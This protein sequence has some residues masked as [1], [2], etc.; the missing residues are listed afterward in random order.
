MRGF[1][2]RGMIW[3]NSTISAFIAF[4]VISVLSIPPIYAQ[5]SEEK[6]EEIKEVPEIELGKRLYH[7]LC[8]YCHGEKGDG[9]GPVA[10]FLNI[11]PRDFRWPRDFRQGIFK[12][13]SSSYEELFPFDKDLART[14]NHGLGGSPMPALRG[15]V[16]VEEIRGVI[17]YIKTFSS[18]EAEWEKP[19]KGVDYSGR[20]PASPESITKGRQLFLEHCSECHGKNADGVT[21]KK[22]K[23]D[24]GRIIKPRDL[25]KGFNY[26]RG[27]APKEIYTRITAG[28]PGTPMPSFAD[29]IR[30]EKRLTN[31]QRWH[32]A[33]YVSS[34]GV[35][36]P[37]ERK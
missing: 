16:T 34:L 2:L 28:I 27:N 4:A 21:M 33:N 29:P 3:K 9:N 7:K 11:K 5:G 18:D 36:F 1:I 14:I 19:T 20:V 15:M 26:R 25:T 23:D 37:I 31:E 35:P 17:E 13:K 32:V 24:W 6:Q 30:G 10:F 22:L 12:F 8:K